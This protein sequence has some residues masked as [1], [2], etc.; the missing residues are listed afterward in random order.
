MLDVHNHADDLTLV[1]RA[2]VADSI[3]EQDMS[4]QEPSH[5]II[6]KEGQH[7]SESVAASVSI[8][9]V[10]RNIRRNR[11]AIATAPMIPQNLLDLQIPEGYQH[12]KKG[13]LFFLSDSGPSQ[14]RTLIFSTQ[15]DLETPRD[16]TSWAAD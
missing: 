2:K 12:F 10:V 4:S 13:Y 7:V 3:K 15:R 1:S 9:N 11:Q 14:H 16:L 8:W 6:A 5:R